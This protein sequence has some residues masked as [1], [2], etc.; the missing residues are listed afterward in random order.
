MLIDNAHLNGNE[1]RDQVIV[2]TG[3]GQGIGKAAA[4]ILG[5][6]G[7]RVV[8]AEINDTGFETERLIKAA[9][10]Q[11]LFVKT[12]VA[13]RA[14]WNGCAIGSTPLSGR[15]MSLSTTPKPRS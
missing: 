15:S 9:G 14:A 11:A 1:L 2:V 10:G 8:I 3:A 7:A 13:D 12:D 5:K 6:S 4:L